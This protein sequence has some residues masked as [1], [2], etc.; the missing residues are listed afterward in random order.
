MAV[1]M[2]AIGWIKAVH[3]YSTAESIKVVSMQW[4]IRWDK[5]EVSAPIAVKD[6]KVLGGVDCHYRLWSMFSLC[7]KHKFKKYYVKL[8]Y[9]Y[10][11]LPS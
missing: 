11:M 2:F 6:Y 8:F 1:N 3:S 7:K 10:W 9:V 4:H 5:M